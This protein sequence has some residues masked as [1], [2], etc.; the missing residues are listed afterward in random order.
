M[1]LR[2]FSQSGFSATCGAKRLHYYVL[3]CMTLG[4]LREGSKQRT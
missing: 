4:S 3:S 1:A 2:T